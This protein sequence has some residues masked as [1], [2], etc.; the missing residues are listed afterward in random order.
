[1]PGLSMSV[2]VFYRRLQPHISGDRSCPGTS[3]KLIFLVKDNKNIILEI[4]A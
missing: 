4:P 3:D 1:M 2:Q